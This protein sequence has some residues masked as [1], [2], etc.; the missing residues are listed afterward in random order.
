[1]KIK[2]LFI[3]LA[4]M[5]CV[6]CGNQSTDAYYTD[7][8]DTETIEDTN[9]EEATAS[10]AVTE[11]TVSEEETGSAQA[12]E[13]I[14]VIPPFLDDV[15]T[16]EIS[17]KNLN[18]GVWD[19]ICAFESTNGG[20][21][22]QVSWEPVEGASCY[23]IYMVD[24]SHIGNFPSSYVVHWKSLNVTETSYETGGT[25][26]KDYTGFLPPQGDTRTY[27]LYVFA[28]KEPIE[29]MKGVKGSPN[30]DFANSIPPIDQTSS[31]EGG[32]LISYGFLTGTYTND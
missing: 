16:F 7:Q 18:D 4:V 3:L 1:M 30:P 9:D 31:G 15:E 23:V 12:D 22:P 10:Q 25:L 2:A 29:K 20:A 8:S 21:S 5:T 17:S 32:N 11:G 14:S 26:T 28:L 6:G 24:S 13:D 19:D 27:D